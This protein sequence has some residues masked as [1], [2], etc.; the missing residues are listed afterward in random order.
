[1]IAGCFLSPTC[2]LTGLVA[3]PLFSP[4]LLEFWSRFNQEE[5]EEGE[6]NMAVSPMQIFVSSCV[7]FFSYITERVPDTLRFGWINFGSLSLLLLVSLV[8]LVSPDLSFSLAFSNCLCLPLSI[9]LSVL[10]PEP[11]LLLA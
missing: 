8:L 9:G 2:W 6:K 3:T 4:T 10:F 7:V 1:M 5:E 11:F